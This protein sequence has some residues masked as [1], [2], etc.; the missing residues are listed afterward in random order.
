MSTERILLHHTL[1]T[2]FPAALRTA[3]TH[4]FGPQHPAPILV[5]SAGVT[6]S[7][8]LLSDAHSKG[9]KILAGDFNAKEDSNTRMRPVVVEGVT[10][11]MDLFYEESFGPSVAV[12][13]W[14]T[15]EEALRLANDTEY[16]LSAAVFTK[17]LARGLRMA[18]GIES[19]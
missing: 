10:K 16:G 6:K 1:A 17:D 7:Q 18:R 4:L 14:E 2:T 9:A 19:G 12:F 3:I 5:T 15:E 8:R 13:N 11:E